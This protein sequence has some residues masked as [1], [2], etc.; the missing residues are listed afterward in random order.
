MNFDMAHGSSCEDDVLRAWDSLSHNW[1]RKA[2][3]LSRPVRIPAAGLSADEG[4]PASLPIGKCGV[5]GC[6]SETDMSW[7]PMAI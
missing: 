3:G 1:F 5:P 7:W 4:Q 2:E 6:R